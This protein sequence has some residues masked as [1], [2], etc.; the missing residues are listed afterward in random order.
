[1]AEMPWFKFFSGDYLGDPD[2]D[3]LPREAEALFVRMLCVIHRE[4]SCPLD[5]ETLARKTH[6]P[7]E[8]VQRYLKVCAV[9]FEERGG[10]FFSV[11][12]ELEKRRSEIARQNA[13]QRYQKNQKPK[14]RAKNLESESSEDGSAAGNA[15]GN[16]NGS[17]TRSRQFPSDFT[18]K[19]SHRVLAEKLGIDLDDSFEKFR[20]HH[21][22]LGN[23]FTNWD[24]ALNKWLRKE[25]SFANDKNGRA[26]INIEDQN[27]Q[28]AAEF[29]K[30]RGAAAL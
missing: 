24:Y 21:L 7:T 15:D 23:L 1:M 3:D 6:C 29:Q 2:V 8:Y 13:N 22:S 19:E 30:R 4:G 25:P 12:M 18:P 11:R 26:L 9:F 14:S 27:K 16:A 20:D 5:I 28:K 17:A 10:R